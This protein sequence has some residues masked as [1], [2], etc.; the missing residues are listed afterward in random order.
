MPKKFMAFLALNYVINK[1]SMENW[2]L[3]RLLPS[4]SVMGMC[5]WKGAHFHNWIDYNGVAFS[6]TSQH[7]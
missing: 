2:G 6:I 5:C 4:N 3:G 7:C 1:L